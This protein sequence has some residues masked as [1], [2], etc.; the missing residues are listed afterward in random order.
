M[1]TCVRIIIYARKPSEKKNRKTNANEAIKT[2]EKKSPVLKVSFEKKSLCY[3]QIVQIFFPSIFFLRLKLINSIFI[4]LNLLSCFY[5]LFE[6]VKSVI[7]RI[8][9]KRISSR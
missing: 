1:A 7:V 5:L 4:E 2:H 8:E 3:E 6:F 9:S